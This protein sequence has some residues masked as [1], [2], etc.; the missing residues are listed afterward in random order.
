MGS[1][2]GFYFGEKKKPKKN[3]LEEKAQQL[4][5]EKTFVLP[6]VQIVAKGKKTE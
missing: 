4:T 3:R 6:K 2:G 5:R 1:F